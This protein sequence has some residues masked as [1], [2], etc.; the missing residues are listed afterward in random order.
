MSCKFST[1]FWKNLDR[2]D[3]SMLK[4]C[5]KKSEF[6][7]NVQVQL[8]ITKKLC[9]QIPWKWHAFL[10]HL[11]AWVQRFLMIFW[12]SRFLEKCLSTHIYPVLGQ[13]LW[14][15]LSVGDV[16]HGIEF[17]MCFKTLKETVLKREINIRLQYIHCYRNG[18]F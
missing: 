13:K 5:T 16:M 15:F 6:V 2:F 14:Y 11:L 18:N 4:K 10:I 17:E 3:K 12:R 7:K 8:F 1:S 9:L